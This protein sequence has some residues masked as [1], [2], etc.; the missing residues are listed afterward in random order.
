MIN[1][2]PS[3]EFYA[4]WPPPP[5][6]RRYRRTNRPTWVTALEPRDEAVANDQFGEQADS[7]GW[8]LPWLWEQLRDP[9]TARRPP[10]TPTAKSDSLTARAYWVPA[11]HLMRYAIGWR[12]VDQ[13]LAAWL[14]AGRPTTGPSLRLLNDVW[15]RDGQLPLLLAWL[16]RESL[17]GNGDVQDLA[18]SE[19]P[20][21]IDWRTHATWIDAV[22]AEAQRG[23]AYSPISPG[24]GDPLHLSGLCNGPLDPPDGPDP[25]EI[26]LNETV[27]V[28]DGG[29]GWYAALEGVFDASGLNG[30][31]VDVFSRSLGWLGTFRR[32]PETG[33]WHRDDVDPY[34]HSVGA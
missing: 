3:S 14:Q 30:P 31:G 8:A 1:R 19:P 6:G 25:D 24:G 11:L 34:W 2:P 16:A 12:R 27:V 9:R 5:R 26:T 32:S 20:S 28:V 21:V 4:P 17:A 23:Y 15:A 22:S 29:R 7:G 13:G 33:R 18:P 10:A